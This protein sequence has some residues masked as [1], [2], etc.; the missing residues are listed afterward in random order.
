MNRELQSV[1]FLKEIKQ[2]SASN[3]NFVFIVLYAQMDLMEI[4]NIVFSV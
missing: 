3:V 4:V 2:Y 1:L